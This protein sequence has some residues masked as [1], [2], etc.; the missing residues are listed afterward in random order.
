MSPDG[1]TAGALVGVNKR[2]GSWVFGLELDADGTNVEE[3]RTRTQN[4]TLDYNGTNT[5]EIDIARRTD[6]CRSSK[7]M[8][9]EASLRGRLGYLASESMLLF[10]TGGLST[11]YVEHEIDCL[12]RTQFF[13][14]TIPTTPFATHT[15]RTVA[16]SNDWEFGW[17]LGLGFEKILADNRWRLRFDYAYVD[18]GSNDQNAEITRASTSAGLT[19]TGVPSAE[20]DWEEVYHKIRFSLI[21]KFGRP[22]PTYKPMK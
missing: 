8:P 17:S 10:L 20:Y 2:N 7:E 1:I 18:L 14:Q 11:A 16:N 13:D 12:T 19:N 3:S 15:T 21:Y 6:T 9:F 5:D 4:T 22:A